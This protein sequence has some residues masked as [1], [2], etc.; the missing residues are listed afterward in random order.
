MKVFDEVSGNNCSRDDQQLYL[1]LLLF[2][3]SADEVEEVLRRE[4]EE[5]K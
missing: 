2:L 3:I 5:L 1:S 4:E